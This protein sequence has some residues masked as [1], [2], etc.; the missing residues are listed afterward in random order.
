[1]LQELLGQLTEVDNQLDSLLAN[2]SLTDEQ[3]IEHDSLVARREQILSSIKREQGR[4]DRERQR[5]ELATQ[6]QHQLQVQNRTVNPGR[7]STPD[8]PF[9]GQQNFLVPA[10]YRRHVVKNFVG[11]RDGMSAEYRAFAFGMF[12]LALMSK[13]MPSKFNFQKASKWVEQNL[14]S[15]HT[16]HDA[17]GM[18][19]LVPEQIMM[20][21][22]L[23]R[24][25]FGIGRRYLENV[26]MISDTASRTK[27]SSGLS[28]YPVGEG[29]PVTTSKGVLRRVNLVAKKWAVASI[30]SSELDED[31]VVSIGDW[32]VRE[33]AYAFALAEDDAIFNGDGTS[34]YHGI[35]GLRTKLDNIDGSGTDSAGVITQGTGNTWAQLTLTDFHKMVG[36]LPQYADTGSAAWMCHKTFFSEVMNKLTLASGG[37]T[38]QE[39][40]QGARSPRPLFLGYPVQVNQKFP[41]TTSTNQIPVVLG[42]YQLAGMFGDRRSIGIS[43]S[44][45]ATIEGVNLWEQ[46]LFAV[47]GLERFDVNWHSVGDASTVGPVVGLKTGS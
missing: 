44:E 37:V 5:Q 6:I 31:S 3:K 19:Y 17:S 10:Q 41:S 18:H 34:T 46:D 7:L 24:E 32:M 27:Q 47:K 26:P 45:H 12:A 16:E 21:M 30:Y 33:I 35:V 14:A 39:V 23:L 38:A 20:D 4:M 8:S 1:M 43:F 25:Q 40:Q 13:S 11:D 15:T 28:A 42:D 22:I 29:Q 36:K 2:D 9:P